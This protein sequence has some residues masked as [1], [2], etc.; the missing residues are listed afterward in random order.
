MSPYDFRVVIEVENYDSGYKYRWD[1][2]KFNN[3]YYIVKDLFDEYL[4][5]NVVP[6][7]KEKDDPFWDPSEHSLIGTTYV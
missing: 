6:K 3:R 4:L 1:I 5:T 7:L 2:E